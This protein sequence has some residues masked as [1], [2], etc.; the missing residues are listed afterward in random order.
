M[1]QV[2]GVQY[3][4]SLVCA[5]LRFC[6]LSLLNEPS[7]EMQ[8]LVDVFDLGSIMILECKSLIEVENMV[9]SYLVRIGYFL[10]TNGLLLEPVFILL[11]RYFS[12]L[13]YLVSAWW[14]NLRQQ[15]FCFLFLQRFH[16]FHMVIEGDL[17]L[18]SSQ[19]FTCQ[20]CHFLFK[21]IFFPTS[22][23][24]GQNLISF[25][26]RVCSNRLALRCCDCLR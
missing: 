16:P 20:G 4:Q 17:R 12:I 3:V 26:K 14:C 6:F 19:I 25:A 5:F 13:I 23:M 10:K 22:R 21:K 1:S 9:I 24:V 8:I 7:T 18:H 2:I 11:V 15:V